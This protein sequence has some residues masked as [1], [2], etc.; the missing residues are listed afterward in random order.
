[1][2]A[3]CARKRVIVRLAGL[4]WMQGKPDLAP[5]AK[6][7][8]YLLELGRVDHVEPAYEVPLQKKK[9]GGKKTNQRPRRHRRVKQCQAGAERSQS[10][11]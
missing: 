9:S 11:W 10:S 8:F 2:E 1:M 4:P 3:S 7:E 5:G 6:T